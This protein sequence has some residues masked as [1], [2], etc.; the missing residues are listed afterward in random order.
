MPLPVGTL[1][2][3]TFYIIIINILDKK[4]D[5]GTSPLAVRLPMHGSAQK[6]NPNMHCYCSFLGHC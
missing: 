1:P 6:I 3:G 4:R 2:T 5:H